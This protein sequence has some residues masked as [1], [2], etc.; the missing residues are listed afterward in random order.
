MHKRGV[1][2][3]AFLVTA[4]LFGG[5]TLVNHLGFRV[6]LTHSAPVG[7]YRL[8]PIRHVPVL[9]RGELVELCAPDLPLLNLLRDDGFIEEG[10]CPDTHAI[11]FLKPVSAVAGDVV[12]I[13]HGQDAM[14]NGNLVPHT[15][16]RTNIPAWPDGTYIVAPGTIWVFSSY[17]TGSLDSRYFG[18]VSLDRVHGRVKPVLVSGDVAAMIPPPNTRG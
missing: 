7:I 16:A 4:A 8:S 17:S 10:S 2:L 6:N 14:V 5:T 3:G 15:V 9:L 18:P 11:P 12:L 1:A 13:Q